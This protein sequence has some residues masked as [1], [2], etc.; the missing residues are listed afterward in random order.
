MAKIAD[1]DSKMS[2]QPISPPKVKSS[3][4]DISVKV[5]KW[6]ESWL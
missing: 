1:V 3:S 6:A 5:E 4:E 2:G